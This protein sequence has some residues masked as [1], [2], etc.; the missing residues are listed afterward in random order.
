ME[1]LLIASAHFVALLSPGPDFFLIMQAALRL[2]LRYAIVVCAGIA[3]G[4]ALYIALAVAGLESIR[5]MTVVMTSMKYLGGVYLLLVGISL[6]RTPFRKDDDSARKTVKTFLHRESLGGQF[7][8]GLTSAVLNPKNIIFYLA[9]FTV[10]VAPDTGLWMRILYGSWMIMVVFFWDVTVVLFFSG[11]MV[12]HRFGRSIF[13][14]EKF[15]GTMLAL[16]GLLLPIM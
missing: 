14:I 15:S 5:E 4:N 13:W 2:P 10:M 8:V 9:L 16:F 12:K 11:G 7:V 6:L 3:T 1:F